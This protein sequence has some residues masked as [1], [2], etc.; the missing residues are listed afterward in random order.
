MKRVKSVPRLPSAAPSLGLRSLTE[1]ARPIR[2]KFSTLSRHRHSSKHNNHSQ[3][4]SSNYAGQQCANGLPNMLRGNNG[5]VSNGAGSP[6]HAPNPNS[7]NLPTSPNNRGRSRGQPGGLDEEFLATL[8]PKVQE[9]LRNRGNQKPRA[10]RFT[11]SFKTTSSMDP[12]LMVQEI[13]KVSTK[14]NP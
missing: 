1:L 12:I 4:S 2:G 8:E 6:L 13:L 7:N 10:L 5:N 11:W 9:Y 3:S 14:P